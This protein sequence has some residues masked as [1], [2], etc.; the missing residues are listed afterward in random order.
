MENIDDKKK[1]N[2]ERQIISVGGSTG[3]TLPR[4]ILVYLDVKPEDIVIIQPE[5][6][7]NGI[8]ISIWKKVCE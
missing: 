3:I 7:K 5:Q 6:G 8:Y 1:I 4:E 2:F